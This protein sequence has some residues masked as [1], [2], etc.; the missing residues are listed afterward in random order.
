M[1]LLL[2]M[3]VCM[4]EG[5]QEGEGRTGQASLKVAHELKLLRAHSCCCG[6][7]MQELPCLPPTE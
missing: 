1:Q 2:I 4:Q 5:D 3:C 6:C 7:A